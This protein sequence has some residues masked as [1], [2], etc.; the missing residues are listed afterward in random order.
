MTSATTILDGA[1]IE[2]GL[3]GGKGFA[4]NQLIEMGA[5]VPPTGS[6]TTDGYRWFVRDA[7]LQRLIDDLRGEGLPDQADLDQA[8]ERVDTAFLEA[9][10]PDALAAEIRD[11]AVDVGG[12]ALLAVRSSATAED[13]AAASFAGQYRSYLESSAAAMTGKTS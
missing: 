12:G 3:V 5:S 2:P 6:I 7:G 10:M 13:M 8:A 4:L 11:L 1:S 9:A